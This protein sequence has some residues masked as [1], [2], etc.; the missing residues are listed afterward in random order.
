LIALQIQLALG[1]EKPQPHGARR[2]CDIT[3]T[4]LGIIG[5]LVG[6]SPAVAQRNCSIARLRLVKAAESI[7]QVITMQQ[8]P[9]D[10][11]ITIT[12]GIRKLTEAAV[13]LKH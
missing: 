3:R 2:M 7:I 13:S 11:L 8:P 12:P 5:F 6:E 10:L 1:I 9:A 4:L